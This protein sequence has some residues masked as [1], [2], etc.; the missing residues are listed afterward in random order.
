[1]TLKAE[2][3]VRMAK[4]FHRPFFRQRLANKSLHRRWHLGSGLRKLHRQIEELIIL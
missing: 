4:K 2:F 1:L 3:T